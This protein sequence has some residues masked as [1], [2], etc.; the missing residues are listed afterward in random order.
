MNNKLI[1]LIL[2][3]LIAVVS[4]LVY[5]ETSKL[6]YVADDGRLIFQNADFLEDWGNLKT[7]FLSPLP[8]ETYEPLPFYRPIVSLTYFLNYHLGK[9]IQD[10]HLFNLGAHTL[11]TIL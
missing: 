7:T 8:V 9:T 4:I 2:I 3:V 6:S 11:N 1:H 5:F 10:Y